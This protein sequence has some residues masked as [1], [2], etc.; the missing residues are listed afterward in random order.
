MN[1]KIE[2]WVEIENELG[3]H[4]R[5]A[6]LFVRQASGFPCRISV[7]KDG[8]KVDGKS[9]MGV[10]ILEAGKG[11]RIRI[12]AEGNRAQA[13]ITALEELVKNKFGEKE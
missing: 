7:E 1:G 2:S 11:S 5:A 3:L 9:I 12:T 8:Q 4:A 10:M 6:A 13:A